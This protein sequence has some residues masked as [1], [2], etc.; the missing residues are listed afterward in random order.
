MISNRRI[1]LNTSDFL[2]G[3]S[4]NHADLI[5]PLDK[6]QINANDNQKISLSV[7][8]VQ[9]PT[10][11]TYIRNSGINYLM[12][13]TS[14]EAVSA[15][16]SVT[17]NAKM[18]VAFTNNIVQPPF[19][20]SSTDQV[21]GAL[22]FYYSSDI[23]S[24]VAFLNEMLQV[25]YGPEEE[26]PPGNLRF[27][28]SSDNVLEATGSG[29]LK[30]TNNY[31]N[32]DVDF[33]NEFKKDSQK[34]GRM[35]GINV[36]NIESAQ[37]WI[38]IGQSGVGANRTPNLTYNIG[39]DGD[40]I[41]VSTNQDLDSFS[42]SNNGNSSILTTIPI[43]MGITNRYYQITKEE[44]DDTPFN[45]LETYFNEYRNGFIYHKNINVFES[46]K[47][48]SGKEIN[49]LR[50]TLRDGENNKLFCNTNIFYEIEV[51]I[52]E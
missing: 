15:S 2:N 52:F 51:I 18:L 8:Q 14:T 29:I 31:W 47:T 19:A 7:C 45:V 21:V 1:Y 20:I 40:A 39:K 42:S 4:D 22:P 23:S 44:F 43:Q 3:D 17:V 27:K 35:L 10:T 38:G 6:A 9:I 48:I 25:R 12:E 32:S 26:P 16:S 24:I 34:L 33:N 36:D 28:I 46:H 41:L 49:N 37:T 30:F 5:F 13:F 50:L 11:L